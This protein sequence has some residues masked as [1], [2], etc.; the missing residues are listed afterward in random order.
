MTNYEIRIDYVQHNISALLLLRRILL[1]QP[2]KASR[3]LQ[4]EG[5][6]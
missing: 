1:E 4:G 5:R 6:R 2:A 3:G